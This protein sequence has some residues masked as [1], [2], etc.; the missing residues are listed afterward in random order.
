MKPLNCWALASICILPLQAFCQHPLHDVDSLTSHLLQQIRTNNEERVIVQP[1]RTVYAPGEKIWFNAVVVNKE[2]NRLSNTSKNVLVDLVNEKDS[3]VAQA[4]LNAG[5]FNTNGALTIGATVENG[6]YWLRGYTRK[7]LRENQNDIYLHPIYIIN[8]NAT[9]TPRVYNRAAV[10]KQ[11]AQ[12]SRPVVQFYPEGGT[13]ATGI[14]CTLVIKATDIN[15]NPLSVAGLVQTEADSSVASFATNRFGL[16]RVNFYPEGNH[17][18]A[19]TLQQGGGAKYPLPAF[20]PYAGQIAV[21]GQ[22]DEWIHAVITLEDSIYAKT[23]TTYLL[24]I[25]GDS[26]CFAAVGKGMYNLSIP[27]SNF[28]GGVASLLLFN[29]AKSLLSERKVFINKDN[30][31]VSVKTNKKNYAARDKVELNLSVS[32]THGDPM[33]ASLNVSVQDERMQTLSDALETDTLQP[34]SS[35]NNWIKNNNRAIALADVD[36][37]M[38]AQPTQ[39]NNYAIYYNANEVDTA[40]EETEQTE[41]LT[42]LHGQLTGRRNKPLKGMVV[43]EILQNQHDF[44]FESDTTNADGKFRLPIPQGRDSLLLNLQVTEKGGYKDTDN[45]ISIDRFMFPSFTTPA[46]AKQKFTTGLASMPSW[47]KASYADIL[48]SNASE[49]WLKPVIVNTVLAKKENYDVSKRSDPLSSIITSDMLQRGGYQN[50]VGNALL[51]VPGVSLSMGWV[52]IYGGDGRGGSTKSEPLLVVDGA[53]MPNTGVMAYL[54]GL[55]WRDIDFIEVLTGGN[56][57]I[58]GM[59]GGNGVVIVNTKTRY[60]QSVEMEN[61]FTL[62]NPV[63]YHVAPAFKMPNYAD[64]LIKAANTPDTRN[65]IYWQG[66]IITDAG[67]KATLNFY[68]ADAATRYVVTV[69]GLTQHGDRI[70]KRMVIDR[71]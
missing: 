9:N 33:L 15:G 66:G 62:I 26:V 11:P 71:K 51:M 13:L 10:Q 22:N 48:Y 65:T 8:K 40:I 20:N 21:T 55:F 43:T 47:Q 34:S 53:P 69:T 38:I 44:F 68:T 58:Y 7:I 29:G 37:L 57:A 6:Y 42:H 54:N 36:M 19:A 12:T 5:A 70:Y 23:A 18:Y 46:T 28:P 61:G 25:S 49:G 50:F 67:G 63:T 17:A 30:Y 35:L 39:H 3:V 31:T 56:A 2:T 14:Q 64:K 32:N 16:A 41:L 1:D 4:V 60:Q 24:G 59:R 52:T 27:V 45:N